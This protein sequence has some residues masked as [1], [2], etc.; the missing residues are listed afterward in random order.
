MGVIKKSA[1][2]RVGDVKSLEQ[3]CLQRDQ[4]ALEAVRRELLARAETS[5][6]FEKMTKFTSEMSR[7]E[8]FKKIMGS[9]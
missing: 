8:I 3:A 1:R 6:D 7:D 5:R 9:S 2:P 4:I